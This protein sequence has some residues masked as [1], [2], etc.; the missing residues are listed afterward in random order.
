MHSVAEQLKQISDHFFRDDHATTNDS[1]K[2]EWVREIEP[3]N[4]EILII[5]CGQ[6]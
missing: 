6:Q 2:T 1:P 4:T 3:A 5:R